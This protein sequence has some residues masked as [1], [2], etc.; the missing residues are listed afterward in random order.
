[1]K[2][3]FVPL[4]GSGE[5]GMNLNLYHLDGKWIVVDCG[6][7]FADDY[8]PGADLIVPDL[9]FIEK[10]KDD[11][12]GMIVTHAHEDHVGGIQY[13][14]PE[15]EC[16]IYTTK[17]TAEFLKLKL[18]ETHFGKQ[19]KIHEIEP[20]KDFELGPFTIKPINLT[21]SIPEMNAMAISTRHG[22]VMHTGDWKFDPDP[23][24]GPPSNLKALQAKGDKGVLALV[25]DSTNVF[26][27]GE[28][29]SEAVVRENLVRLVK[30]CDNRV[31]VGTFASNLARVE[32]IMHAATEAGRKVIVCGRSFW[33]LIEAARASGY[34]Q[35]APELL[36]E[37]DFGKVPRQQALLLCTGSQGEP[38]AAFSRIAEGTHPNLKLAKGDT[39][40]FSS[41]IIPGNDKAIYRML[42]LLTLQGVEVITEK[43]DKIHV[44]GHPYRN[45]LK[46]MYEYTKP[47]IAV[48]VHGE[49]MH[50]HA[51]AKLAKSLGVKQT[52]EPKN[53]DV[54]ALAPEAELIGMVDNGHLAIDG[55]S[56]HYGDGE[57]MRNR[58]KMRHSGAIFA[59]VSISKKGEAA[60]LPKI[61]APG[62]MDEGIEDELLVTIAEE[63]QSAIHGITD[64]KS[65]ESK[66]KK[67]I[68]R[69]LR[70]EL[71]KNPVIIVH[72]LR[73]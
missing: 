11:I 28:S 5:I 9:S 30:S 46:R 26:S 49:A 50:I 29:G 63:V 7:G 40:I 13:L 52:F 27:E 2:L 3:I 59:S 70:T 51:H 65:I 37:H 42:N 21:H 68:K 18:K 6:V 22:I 36:T 14:W 66:T 31:A 25:C 48:P 39:A 44:S 47:Q 16:P 8:L 62:A 58:R 55:Y 38:R 1:D 64:R 67:I 12:L 73:N 34:L 57:L 43:N 33:R 69:N 32:T 23:M 17:F 56:F 20:G 53:G 19:V 24:V 45:E 71:D 15:F 60:E 10:I 41:K 35:D 61:S 54:I 4:G 72:V